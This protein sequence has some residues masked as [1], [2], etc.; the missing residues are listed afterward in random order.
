[1]CGIYGLVCLTPAAAIDRHLLERM[2]TLMIHRGPDD[3][4]CY[5]SDTAA[6]GMQRLSILDLQGGHQPISNEDGTV[7][8]VCNGEIYNY[9]ELQ[10]ELKARGHTFRTHSDTEVLVHLYEEYGDRLVQKLRGMYGFAI[11]DEPRRRLV[12]GRD[13]L[14]I[15]P[16]YLHHSPDRL[17]FASEIKAL[18]AD[19]TIPRRVDPAALSE[20]LSWGYVPAPRTLF[21]GIHKLLPGHLLIVEGGKVSTQQYWEVPCHAVEQ[22]SEAEWAEALRDKLSEAVRLH[23]LSDVP[24]GAFLS[25]GLDSSAVVCLMAQLT[26][27]PVQTFSIGFG[28]GD[29]FYNELPYAKVVAEACQTKHQEIIVRP[30]IFELLPKLIWHLDEPI[31]DSAFI[32]TYLVS[33][34]ARRSVTVIL[35]GVGGDELFG[36]YR[37]YLGAEVARYY[38]VLPKFLRHRLLPALVKQLPADRHSSLGNSLRYVKAFV[39]SSH[40]NPAASYLRYLTVFTEEARAALLHRDVA[41]ALL[42]EAPPSPLYQYMTQSRTGHPLH[43]MMF[44]DLKTQLPDDLLA[45]TD[46]MSMAVSIECRVPFL[47]HE[48]VELAARMPADL[49]VHRLCLKYIF[50]KAM[51]PLVPPEILRRKKRGFGAPVG[52]WLRGALRPLTLDILSEATIKRRGFFAW[53]AVQRTMDLHFSKQED[54]T[55][56]LLALI[57]FELWCRIYLDGAGLAASL[58]SVA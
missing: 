47:D 14:G 11:W 9:Q 22:R 37:R 2:S 10:R 1:M 32:T 12:I 3:Q 39:G 57:N 29:E 7:W 26:S 43:D 48:L 18:L 58:S 52:A 13:R 46:K 8:V 24:L 23:L 31:A 27:Q 36:G 6:I 55:D 50:K 33:E 56:H 53:P 35:S 38:N 25:G 5:V 41:A 15:K 45:L 17:L 54:H 51:T 30:D 4:G 49:K 19:P 16:V 42:A 40:L 28:A 44:V 34:F 21:A 20:Y